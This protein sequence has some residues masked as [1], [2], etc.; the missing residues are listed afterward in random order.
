[1]IQLTRLGFIGLGMVG[2]ATYMAATESRA[3]CSRYDPEKGFTDSMKGCQFVFVAVPVPTT[4]ES[5]Q[6]YSI[7]IES[8]KR[9]LSESPR[10]QIL[11][12]STV[13]PGTVTRLRK[14]I[15]Y[16]NIHSMPEFLS[17]RTWA[18]DMDRLP[19]LTSYSGDLTGIFVGKEILKT[20]TPEEAELI[21]YTHNSFAAMKVEFFNQIH[22]FCQ[23]SELDFEK[24]A[25]YT[26]KVS[27]FISAHHTQVPGPDGQEGY[28]GHC[29]PKDTK[30]FA[31]FLGSKLLT[32]VNRSNSNRR[33]EIPS[34]G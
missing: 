26:T 13:L 7:L 12:R 31:Y 1:M 28:G 19:V 14:L 22:D 25:D 5:K 2:N 20:D 17:E 21:K 3:M 34:E 16:K 9:A 29:L 10:A 27:P 4:L 33:D 23:F 15:G 8:I 18:E 32:E 11:I 24:V 6:D 30:A